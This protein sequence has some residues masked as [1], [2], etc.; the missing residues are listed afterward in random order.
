MI[1][2]LIPFQN[3]Y[4]FL[5]DCL[6]SVIAQTE[7][8]LEI[9]LVNDS[10]TDNSLELLQHYNFNIPNVRVFDSP[11]Y[12]LVD[13]LNFGISKTTY[14]YIARLDSDDKMVK[15]RLKLQYDFLN[16]N[17]QV[18]VVGTQLNYMNQEGKLLGKVSH[19]P[20]EANEISKRIEQG[21]FLAHPSVMFRKSLIETLG[22]YRKEFIHAED[23]DLWLRV[24]EKA[25][26]MNIDL[27]LTNYRQ[28]PNQISIKKR[29]QQE[30]STRAAQ[31]SHM[32]RIGKI[33]RP[34]DVPS[35]HEAL[36]IWVNDLEI[37]QRRSRPIDF[38][39]ETN[40]SKAMIFW[41]NAALQLSLFQKI[42]F[43]ILA[44]IFSPI[45]TIV[46]LKYF[47][48]KRVKNTWFKN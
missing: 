23:Y 45:I 15:G 25:Q 29:N 4:D 40:K 47:I 34:K 42:K 3:S 18:G 19:Y 30:L 36:H 21:C 41:T 7:V 14:E 17:P 8:E 31:L 9:I 48:Q 12:G 5:I 39:I 13:A 35:L 37:E 43:I 32:I 33:K 38:L 28:H 11:G 26:L 1:S 6:D 20:C 46:N 22:G 2:V 16:A 10:S 44:F 24:S 27:A